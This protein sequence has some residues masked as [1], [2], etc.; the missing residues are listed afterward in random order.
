MQ[1]AGLQSWKVFMLL[2]HAQRVEAREYRSALTRAHCRA[3]SGPKARRAK[4]LTLMVTRAQ[5]PAQSSSGHRHSAGKSN[6]TS[7]RQLSY[8]RHG[9][10][11]N[12]GRRVSETR[13][14]R[15]HEA[16]R[17]S[18]LSII[19]SWHDDRYSQPTRIHTREVPRLHDHLKGTKPILWPR[20]VSDIQTGASSA[21]SC[22]NNKP[23]SC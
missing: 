4:P 17:A 19:A 23:A 18:F 22:A 11:H 21:C 2:M 10:I 5:Q 1:R 8:A 13:P 3:G 16:A 6:T 9:D 14:G 7:T 15:L 20:K 12:S